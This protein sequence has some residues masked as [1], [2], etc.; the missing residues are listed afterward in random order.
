MRQVRQRLAGEEVSA[1][2]LDTVTRGEAETIAAG[3]C[4]K[5]AKE[6][7]RRHRNV[8]TATR[9]AA[10][11]THLAIKLEAFAAEDAA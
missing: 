3:I 6:T 10:Q 1:L 2:D 9:E 5:L 8:A 11:L 7:Y 4:R